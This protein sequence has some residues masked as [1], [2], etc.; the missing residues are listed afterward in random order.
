MLMLEPV[1][2]LP[3][4]DLPPALWE[5]LKGPPPIAECCLPKGGLPS[6]RY[7]LLNLS[8]V[9]PVDRIQ[10]YNIYK[11]LNKIS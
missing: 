5:T 2:T 10:S 6:F 7:D 9:E 8:S 3:P 1:S 11:S 4:E